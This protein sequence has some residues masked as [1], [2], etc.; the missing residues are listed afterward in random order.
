MKCLLCV[1]LAV[2]IGVAIFVANGRG[3]SLQKGISVQMAT[4]SH[5]AAMPEADNEK[6]WI[7]TVTTDG[8][9]FFGTE[10]VTAEELTGQMKV[11]PRNRDAKLYIKADAGVPFYS[12]RQVLNSARV[13]LFDDVVLLT[14]QPE[15]S[16]TGAIVPP[17]GL[18]VWI[19]SEVG[20]NFAAVQIGSHENSST[21]K[22]NN[23]PIAASGLQGKMAKLFDSRSGGRIVILKADDRVPYSQVVHAVDAC[24]GAGASRVTIEVAS[25]I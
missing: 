24:N 15:A 25:E 16:Q 10:L 18:G 1:Y 5:A 21:V 17:K 20:S 22:V 2:L 13:V 7:V 3:Q 4:S 23:E 9:I 12:V 11:R 14:S 6:A 19:G 8:S